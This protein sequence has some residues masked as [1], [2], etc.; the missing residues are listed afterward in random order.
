MGDGGEVRADVPDLS[1]QLPGCQ[2]KGH[3][4]QELST[5]SAH[6]G[7]PEKNWQLQETCPTCPYSENLSPRESSSVPSALVAQEGILPVAPRGLAQGLCWASRR[8]EQK[9]RSTGGKRGE[10][11]TYP[12]PG[13][14]IGW[15][16]AE[17]AQPAPPH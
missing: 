15:S 4:P 2:A 14:P 12:C 8:R 9:A 11:G 17:R 5:F 6:R 10:L 1:A 3:T 13:D 16:L 7:L